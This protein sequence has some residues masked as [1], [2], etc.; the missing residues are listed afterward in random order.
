MRF[1]IPVI[2]AL[3]FVSSSLFAQPRSFPQQQFSQSL[4]QSFQRNLLSAHPASSQQTVSHLVPV[5]EEVNA[6]KKGASPSSVRAGNPPQAQAIDTLIVGL[7]PNDT[8]RI[9]G[10]WTHTGPIWVFNDGVLIFDHADVIDTG[11]VYV[12]GHGQLLADSSDFFFPQHYFYERSLLVLQNAV[13]SFHNSSFNYS[14]MS[15]NLIV[16]NNA[17]LDWVNVHQ[18]DWTTCGLFGSPSLNIHGCN[19]SGEYILVDSCT[20]NF[21]HADSIILWHQL[22]NTAVINYSFPNG[23]AVYNYAFDNTVAGVSGLNYHVTA[24]SCSTVWWAIMPVNGSDVTISNSDIR[25]I[26]AWFMNGDTA[27]AYGIFNN[28]SYANYLTPL[29]DRTLHLVNTNVSTWNFYVFD[30]SFLSIDSCQLGEVGTQQVSNVVASNFILDG[31]G[32]YFWATDTSA[33]LATNVISYNT[34]RSEMNGIFLLAYSWL[35]FVPPTSIEQSMII[36]V[37]NTLPA[38]PIPYDASVAWLANME[39]PDT[40]SVN[41]V[42]PIT[43]SAWINQ[44]PLGN[45]IDFASYSLYFQMPSMSTAW[46]PIVVDSATE[47]SHGVLANWNTTG[48]LPGTYVLIEVLTDNFGDS[49]AGQRLIELLPNGVG[50]NELNA[51]NDLTVFPNPSEGHF[52]IRSES[53]LVSRIVVTDL[54]GRVVLEQ[55]GVFSQQ[56]SIDLSATE[57]GVYLLEVF[58]EGKRELV[59]LVKE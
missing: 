26:G 53:A 13:A 20:A 43:G 46:F 10:T 44:G 40:S 4:Q 23:N 14:G 57:K 35:P 58:T 17:Q 24:D 28:S 45:A 5:L 22:P 59:R 41:A 51:S 39:G 16:A 37:Q 8:V 21:V 12:F 55:D 31:T 2:T 47:I 38:D 52:I 27:S 25:L 18:H 36:C 19:L 49:V 54:Q 33:I 50:V 15:H 32:G 3:L 11:D 34:T 1:F 9:T 42:V 48:L 7:V 29:N 6:L 30:N 56:F